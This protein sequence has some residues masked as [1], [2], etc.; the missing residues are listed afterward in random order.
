MIIVLVI[1][2]VR[3]RSL[4]TATRYG[5]DDPG[6]EPRWGDIFPTRP[7]RPWGPPSPPY[8]G[9]RVSFLGV[10]PPGRGVGHPPPLAPKLK[11]D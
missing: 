3:G 4:G 11:K 1:V 8:K 5:L 2:S 7:D 6:I 9:Y 10:K